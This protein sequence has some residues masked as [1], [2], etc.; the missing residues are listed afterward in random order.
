MKKL[1]SLV[2][3]IIPC[4]NDDKYI[5][6]AINSILNQTYN[7]VEIIV[8]DDGSNDKT[9]K[10]LKKIEPKVNLLITQEN[11]G[12]ST[13]RNKGI[14]MA[15]GQFI[16][17]LDSDDFF[18]PTFI[19]QAVELLK[20]DENI[21]IV[22]C[23]ANLINEKGENKKNLIYKPLGN[24]ISKFKFFNGALGSSMFLKK[25]WERIGG[26]D[27]KMI[28]G[29]EDWEFY[30]RILKEG[31]TAYVIKERLFNYRVKSE[32]TSSRAEIVKYDLLKYIY[33]K[34]E[35]LYANDF[36]G[37]VNHL[38]SRVESQELYKKTIKNQIDFKIGKIV[39]KP[40]RLIKSIFRL[41]IF[42]LWL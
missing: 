32:S 42:S 33:F 28:K 25:D 35:E 21:K 41:K 11:K 7:N 18:L 12:Q 14:K 26:Y 30:I 3:V 37:L 34:H 17:T 24:S 27:E 40:F 38:L 9:K 19:E 39:L 31:G 29:F 36:K 2:S 16:L 15:K 5:E 6:Q 23:Y 4:Y 1:N 13:A 20:K 10:V 22:T 8:I